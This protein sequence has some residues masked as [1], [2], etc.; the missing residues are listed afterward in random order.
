[1][2]PGKLRGTPDEVTIFSRA[3]CGKTACTV[4]R[5]GRTTVLP[6]PYLMISVTLPIMPRKLF[7]GM[8]KRQSSGSFE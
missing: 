1:F 3:V 4:R 7:A 5:A 2:Q 6:D 8:A